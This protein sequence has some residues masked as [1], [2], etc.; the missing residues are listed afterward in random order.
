MEFLTKDRFKEELLENRFI[1]RAPFWRLNDD[2]GYI[3]RVDPRG[4][5][6]S[7]NHRNREDFNLPSLLEPK[8]WVYLDSLETFSLGKRYIF[9]FKP[10][11]RL[12]EQGLD[13]ELQHN[14]RDYKPLRFMVYN[15]AESTVLIRPETPLGKLYFYKKDVDDQ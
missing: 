5:R 15:N 8:S 1:E 3:L 10:H 13:I 14:M 12:V 6:N 11:W 2:G 7:R 4:I 9:V